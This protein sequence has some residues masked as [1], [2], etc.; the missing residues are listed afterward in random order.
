M[1]IVIPRYEAS[2]N[3]D[4][5][6]Y[7]ARV[8]VD[9][10]IGSA[11]S[12]LGNAVTDMGQ[13]Q[14][15]L[16]EQRDRL[17]AEI[18]LQ[19][20]NEKW[21]QDRVNMATTAA[22]DGRD[23]EKNFK[24]KSVDPGV[25]AYIGSITNPRIKEEF[26]LRANL[27]AQKHLDAANTDEYNMG[28][29]FSLNAVSKA[30]TDSGNGI[31][32]DPANFDSYKQQVF[33]RIDSAP[34]L[35]TAQ[36]IEQKQKWSQ[37]APNLLAE[38][39]EKADPETFKFATKATTNDERMTYLAKSVAPL[40]GKGFDETK[41][42][43]SKSRGDIPTTVLT[44][45][46]NDKALEAYKKDGLAGLD[47]KSKAA[48][49]AVMGGMGTKVFASG[50]NLMDRYSGQS[51]L[52]LSTIRGHEGFKTKAYWD[53]NHYR[54]G[55]GS[56][57]VT[58]A[59][60]TVENVG[61]NT[62]ASR[63]DAERDLTRRVIGYQ[64]TIV[65]AVGSAAWEALP[66]GAKAAL[67]SIVHN[68][69]ELPDRILGA[70]KSGNAGK[71]A[72]AILTLQGDNGGV[73]AGRR[74]AEANLALG[75][76]G[77]APRN[78]SGRKAAVAG[79][80]ADDNQPFISASFEGMAPAHLATVLA[81]GQA[82]A[83]QQTAQQKAAIEVLKFT[84]KADAATD[85]ASIMQS[86]KSTVQDMTGFEN[87]LLQAHGADQLL[88]Y[89]QDRANA[90][91]VWEMSKDLGSLPEQ[92][93]KT[94]LAELEPKGGPNAVAQ[95]FVYDNVKA[96]VAKELKSRN[97]DPATYV[98]KVDQSANN[99]WKKFNLNDPSSVGDAYSA[100]LAAQSRLGLPSSP[101]P[102]VQA[103]RVADMVNNEEKSPDARLSTL[104]GIVTA[105]KDPEQQKAIIE[106]LVKQGVPD[107]IH[108]V[109]D[110]VERGDTGAARRLFEAAT[111]KAL[112]KGTQTDIE[113]GL[114]ATIS[115]RMFGHGTLGEVFY[116][117]GM[118]D[119]A[120]DNVASRDF[121]LAK[122]AA[123]FN[124]RSGKSAEEAANMAI[125]DII[126]KKVRL[127][128]N[129]PGGG[130]AMGILD[131]AVD[132]VKIASGMEETIPDVR[133]QLESAATSEAAKMAGGKSAVISAIAKAHIDRIMAEGVFRQRGDG[134][135]FFDPYSNTFVTKADGKPM[136]WTDA[137]FLRS[138]KS[139][140]DF[141]YNNL[142][143]PAL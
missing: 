77:D 139:T 1:G 91:A 34:F 121:S 141:N 14:Q 113:K 8:H 86:G 25:A 131:P 70:V 52:A 105:T 110:A 66:E 51:D 73:N 42:I 120:A 106:Q 118:H 62:V 15:N 75:G 128:K 122:S 11:L 92:E 100:T 28:N 98:A 57:T 99:A 107:T 68:Y 55:Y 27:L 49:N 32:A 39:L 84:T 6:N 94:R 82:L 109:I 30:A 130:H 16:A 142:M 93:M 132:R 4:P 10:S 53:V 76:A 96:N 125:A 23:F 20:R 127:D 12:G 117:V 61:P 74:Q 103:K 89:R 69:G 63:D 134:W 13:R 116:G 22:P 17:H 31:V 85:V 26:Q 67:S 108:A 136:K 81:K 58:R 80:V 143:V 133:K 2:V 3:V 101:L 46:G 104:A 47:D 40:M 60:G 114:E 137:D 44:M 21:G 43:L 54:V 33:E 37:A 112:P 90:S 18:G 24:E 138:A 35:T 88:Q 59:D 19:E 95:Q 36:K 124:M 5:G 41:A 48:V 123:L 65:K 102:S 97:D 38:G 72:D 135:G 7:P 78:A 87:N 71:V 115:D 129:F 83:A 119:P 79:K 126:G 29:S 45:L 56:D 140:P 50:A 9:D 64:K 111:A